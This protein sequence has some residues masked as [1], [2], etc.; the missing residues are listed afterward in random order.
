MTEPTALQRINDKL[1][2]IMEKMALV[3]AN[4]ARD[5]QRFIGIDARFVSMG[6]AATSQLKVHDA[7]CTAKTVI[8]A[9]TKVVEA[10]ERAAAWWKGL[11]RTALV[12]V[13]SAAVI[14][15]VSWLLGIYAQHAPTGAQQAPQ[16]QK[17]SQP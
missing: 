12:S 9:L 6:E 4:Q 16:A 14:I 15:F 5:L 7:T 2:K 1:D 11:L 17:V 8:V 10:G 13:F 3:E